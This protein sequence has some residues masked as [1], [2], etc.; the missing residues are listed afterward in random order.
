MGGNYGGGPGYGN[1]QW[2]GR[3]ND[4]PVRPQEFQ[5]TYRNTMQSL[6]QL[7]GQLRDDPNM[8]RDIQSLM[9]DLRAIDPFAGGSDPLLTARIAAALAG[10]EQVEME[11]RRK[12][13]EAAGGGS[14]RSPGGEKVPAGYA[15]KVAEYYRKLGKSK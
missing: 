1:R 12:V 2:D 15:D 4:G 8:A 14:V 11:L 13:E 5:Q 7:Q 6:Q 3:Y 9:R 10:V